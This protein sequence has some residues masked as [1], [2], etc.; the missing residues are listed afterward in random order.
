MATASVTNTFVALTTAEAA[1]VNT[2]FTDLV[3]FL[4]TNVVH[5]DGSVTMT[6]Q[7]T[8]PGSDPSTSNQAAR[9]A[10]VDTLGYVGYDSAYTAQTGVTGVTDITDLSI[11][12]TAVSGRAYR[13]SL[14]A[15]TA[16]VTTQ[17]TQEVYLTNSSNTVLAA[18]KFTV[19][20]G[21][22]ATTHHCQT[23]LTGISGSYTVKGRWATSAGTL[24]SAATSTIPHTLIVEDLGPY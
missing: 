6:G 7:L 3:S 21:S 1:K 4:N 15:V 18:S 13:V 5:K 12:F 24:D 19:P 17:G 14:N 16:Q 2:N 20:N 10:Y 8:L 23:V 9:K 11:A 22:W